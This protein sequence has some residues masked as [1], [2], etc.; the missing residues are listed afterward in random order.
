MGTKLM[1]DAGRIE[2]LIPST[3]R[4]R[5]NRC[6]LRIYAVRRSMCEEGRLGGE[7]LE[8]MMEEDDG[9]IGCSNTHKT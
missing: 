9:C 7:G 1:E 8:A 4:G 6:E 2:V 3:P 5:S